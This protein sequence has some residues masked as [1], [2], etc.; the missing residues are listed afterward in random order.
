M[1][2]DAGN[3]GLRA[4]AAFEAA[5]GALAL[6]AGSGLLLL[7]H[8]DAQASV[9]A[10][11]RHLHLNPARLHGGAI[12]AALDGASAHLT[13]I[14]L[15][16][17][18]YASMRFI[19]AWGLWRARTWAEWFGVVSGLVYVPFDVLEI[20][21]RPGLLSLAMLALNLLIV[22]VLV[23]RLATSRARSRVPTA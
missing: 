10:L 1:A 21:H 11:A 15:A 17:V 8:A 20:A 13:W 23:R 19:E 6:L 4:V 9:D 22:G 16:G 18:A 2:T 3:G 7:W 5:K 12:G 14:A